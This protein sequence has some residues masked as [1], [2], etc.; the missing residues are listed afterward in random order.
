MTELTDTDFMNLETFLASTPQTE[1]PPVVTLCGSMRFHAQMLDVAAELS[2]AGM[3]VLAPFKVVPPDQQHNAAKHHLDELHRRKI[4]L[5]SAIVVVTDETGYYGD[6]TRG[7]I[8]YAISQ[9]KTVVWSRRALHADEYLHMVSRWEW[10]IADVLRLR[11]PR[12]L[13]GVLLIGDPAV[14]DPLAVG[15]PPC[16]H[17]ER[18]TGRTGRSNTSD[19]TVPLAQRGWSGVP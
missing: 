12:S 1:I 6:S 19:S 8:D 16:P 5:S 10:F 11:I 4:D 15:A 13:C 18:A 17:C 2:E 7:E 14:P 3:I 9:S